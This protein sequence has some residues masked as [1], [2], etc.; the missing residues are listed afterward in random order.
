MTITP[1]TH[2]V[3]NLKTTID[4]V[5][6]KP[7]LFER[8]TI[9]VAI[10][11]NGYAYRSTERLQHRSL[12][13]EYRIGPVHSEALNPDDGTVGREEIENFFRLPE[14]Y[15]Y[16]DLVLT[17]DRSPLMNAHWDATIGLVDA[18]VVS[19]DGAAVRQRMLFIGFTDPV[20]AEFALQVD[21]A[22]L[23]HDHRTGSQFFEW[24]DDNGQS[25]K[26]TA[27]DTA[28]RTA[29]AKSER[30]WSPLWSKW[31]RAGFGGRQQRGSL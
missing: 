3:R 28:V 20:H 11:R 25:S 9:K 31:W 6:D 29:T 13:S 14:I 24:T 10:C 12:V 16:S 27:A 30:L 21:Q 5:R 17:F 15:A 18:H 2:Y 7:A 19:I 4:Q 22:L 26:V 1:Y 8:A 23:V